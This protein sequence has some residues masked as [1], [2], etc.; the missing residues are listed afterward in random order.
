MEFD[1]VQGNTIRLVIDSRLGDVFLV[2]LAVRGICQYTPLEKEIVGQLEI[3]VV[4]AV[5]NAIKHAYDGR[6][7]NDVRI[8]VTLYPDRI[9]CAVSDAGRAMKR[10]KPA[11]QSCDL[12][13]PD[14]LPE[15]GRGLFIIHCA[16]DEVDY[17]TEDGWNTLTMVK[18][19]APP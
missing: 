17:R 3:S 14:S 16:M 1:S 12:G 10:M 18:Y 7:G 4:E 6:T 15:S 13:N 8:A 9:V 2:G 5:N 19:T 11:K